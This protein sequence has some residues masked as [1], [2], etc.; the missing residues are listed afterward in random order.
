[1][2]PVFTLAMEE[3][4]NYLIYLKIISFSFLFHNFR[5]I[6]IAR[7]AYDVGLRS[8]ITGRYGAGQAK[9]AFDQNQP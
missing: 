6:P 1:M 9:I 5:I 3:Q 4:R 8:V 7:P 2:I